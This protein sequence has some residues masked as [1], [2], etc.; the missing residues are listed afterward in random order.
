MTNLTTKRS[1]LAQN[2]KFNDKISSRKELL[3]ELAN[4]I[5]GCHEDMKRR[6]HG[7]SQ[8]TFWLWMRILSFDFLV[9]RNSFLK[10]KHKMRRIITM[11]PI[12]FFLSFSQN[13]QF[14][15][16]RSKTHCLKLDGLTSIIDTAPSPAFS[17]NLLPSSLSLN[18][19][20]FSPSQTLSPMWTR[21]RTRAESRCAHLAYSGHTGLSCTLLLLL[22]LLSPPAPPSSSCSSF[23]SSFSLRLPA[24]RR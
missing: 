19:P 14:P 21:R 18:F 11:E 7:F 16:V 15:F 8:A 10:V 9:L 20:H 1:I 3:S 23:S 5:L 12:N 2:Y 24:A 4:V 22:L 6:H 13:C 17:P